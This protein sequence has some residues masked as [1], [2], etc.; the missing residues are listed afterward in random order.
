[1]AE[2]VVQLATLGVGEHL[3]RLDHLTETVLR[4][5][6]VGDIRMQLPGEPAKRALDV[7][8]AGIAGDA[9]ELVVVALG[10]QLSS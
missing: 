3:V 1:V 9:E 6:C 7:V 8:R 10:A 5:R 2:A 4:V